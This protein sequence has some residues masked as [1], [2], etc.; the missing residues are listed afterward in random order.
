MIAR[1]LCHSLWLLIF[2]PERKASMLR[3]VLS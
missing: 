2:T 3:D 1:F